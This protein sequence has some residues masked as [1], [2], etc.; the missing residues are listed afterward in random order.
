MIV[1]APKIPPKINLTKFS[2]EFKMSI[3]QEKEVSMNIFIYKANNFMYD[4]VISFKINLSLK[5]M[6]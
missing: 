5:K 3:T 6:F 2:D 4:F 1:I